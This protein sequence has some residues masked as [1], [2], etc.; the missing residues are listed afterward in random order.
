MNKLAKL[1][2]TLL[3]ISLLALPMVGCAKPLTVS[4]IGP[5]EGSTINTSQVEV[6]GFVS[7]SKAT[8]WVDDTTVSVSKKGYYSTKLELAEGENTF[9]VIASRGKP[10]N[11]KD[12]V[13]R[14]VSVTYSP[15]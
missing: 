10:G 6:R 13:S 4:I 15:K 3:I 1:I 14:T 2:C 7:D 5:T 11:W 12:T 8:V 9:K